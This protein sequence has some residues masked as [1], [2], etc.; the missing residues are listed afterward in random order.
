MS[1]AGSQNQLSKT[2]VLKMGICSLPIPTRILLRPG[3]PLSPIFFAIEG[4]RISAS[5]SRTFFPASARVYA[6]FMDVVLLPSL[7]VELVTPTILHFL[8]PGIAKSRF[9]LRSLYDSA[10]ANPS[11]LWRVLLRSMGESFFW[12]PNFIIYPR[13]TFSELEHHSSFYSHNAL[14]LH[15]KD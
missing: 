1:P 8:L 15:L 12:R 4:I 14:F 7:R 5:T 13:L 6:R 2:P 9:V 11:L 3:E 10:A